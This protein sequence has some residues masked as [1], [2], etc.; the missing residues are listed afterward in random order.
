[1]KSYIVVFK[2]GTA[3]NTIEQAVDQVKKEGGKIGHRYDSV[4]LGFSCEIP[5]QLTDSLKSLEGV[6]YVEEDQVMTIQK[7]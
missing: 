1:M 4:L 5:E 3:K 7:E 6:D 2:Q